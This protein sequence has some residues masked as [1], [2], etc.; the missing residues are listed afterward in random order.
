M[1][2]VAQ[3]QDRLSLR[4]SPGSKQTLERAAACLDKTLTDFVLDVALRQAEQVVRA[5]TP[6][7]SRT[8]NGH[9]SRRC[10]S[11]RRRPMSGCNRHSM[12][13]RGS[14]NGDLGSG[15]AA[16]RAARGES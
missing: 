13:M 5:H 12:S 14:S 2:R 15:V 1:P 11:I 8:R 6:S 7:C 16:Y 4:L 3:R 10:C 9:A